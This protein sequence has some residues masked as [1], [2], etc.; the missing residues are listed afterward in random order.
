[1]EFA[2]ALVTFDKPGLSKPHLARAV[3][4]A[5]PGSNLARS[6]ESNHAVGGKSVQEIRAT[7]GAADAADRGR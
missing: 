3:A 2:A 4:G 6:I 7:L 1:M 5:E